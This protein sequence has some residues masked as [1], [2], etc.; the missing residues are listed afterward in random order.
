MSTS[1]STTPGSSWSGTY[2]YR[3]RGLHRPTSEAELQQRVSA[4]EHVRAL[5]TRHSFTAIAD[6]QGELVST[7]GLPEVFEVDMARS[8][9][10]ISAGTTYARL[11]ELLAPHGLALA[12][13]PSLPHVCV[14]GAVATGTH[15]SGRALGSLATQVTGLRIVLSDGDVVEVARDEPDVAGYVVSLGALGIVTALD[16]EVQPVY[17]VAQ[18]AMSGGAPLDLV[19]ALDDVMVLGDS[20]SVFTRWS[21]PSLVL[22]K[23][24]LPAAAPQHPMLRPL[25][26]PVHVLPGAD[27][28]AMTDQLGVA[29]PWHARLPH[30]RAD[31]VPSQ[32]AEIQSEYFVRSELAGE[33]VRALAGIA[34][35]LDP[36]LLVSEIRT[37][38]ADGLWLSG[39]HE[40]DSVGLHFTWRPDPVAVDAA[41]QQ[42]EAALSPYRP[43]P[44]WGKRFLLPPAALHEAWPR[45]DDFVRLARALDPGG[46]LTNPFLREAIGL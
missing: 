45:L 31:A 23:R 6:S 43:R 44:H 4:L 15:G 38:A 37:V 41:V 18:W 7:L 21:G 14:G 36:V 30:F 35:V 27:P 25:T 32:G 19:G 24:R 34:E 22:V 11:A 1:A 12:N 17:Q 9:V 46:K 3:A 2:H 39:A 10:R 29:G 16:L 13:L 26:E 28:A 20:V 8:Q 40:S 5:G 42:V 33:A